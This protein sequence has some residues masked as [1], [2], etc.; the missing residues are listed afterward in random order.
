MLWALI[1][2][3][4]LKIQMK[5]AGFNNQPADIT[6]HTPGFYAID[7]FRL[8][9]YADAMNKKLD[10]AKANHENANKKMA[11]NA[12]AG[13][14]MPVQNRSCLRLLATCDLVKRAQEL[15][16]KANQDAIAA[17]T[18][19]TTAEQITDIAYDLAYRNKIDLLK[20]KLL[21]SCTK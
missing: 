14:P 1:V 7:A 2:S 12:L 15:A 4:V 13:K 21:K 9:R 19:N 17:T 10:A 20:Y 18:T 5:K 8:Q 6:E 11:H 3:I 16:S